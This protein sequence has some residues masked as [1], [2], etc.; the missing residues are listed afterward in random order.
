MTAQEYLAIL[1]EEGEEAAL[2]RI[3]KPQPQVRPV[4][5][6]TPANLD[7]ATPDLSLETAPVREEVDVPMPAEGVNFTDYLVRSGFAPSL[8]PETARRA[9]EID[10]PGIVENVG[11]GLNVGLDGLKIG[12]FGSRALLEDDPVVR[13]EFLTR[14]DEVK[15]KQLMDGYAPPVMDFTEIGNRK[16][17]VED[18]FDWTVG[19]IGTMTPVVGS[20]MAGGFAGGKLGGLAGA[21]GGPKGAA[22]GTLAGSVTGSF[23]VGWGLF[24]GGLYADL[25]EMGASPAVAKKTALGYA[26]APSLF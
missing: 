24:A 9:P 22:I 12:Y 25:I 17:V 23:S 7:I 5:L 13:E 10:D 21:A 26:A 2:Q 19:A 6:S 14:V 15:A 18:A 4:D 20:I 16:G 1:E 11:R 3:D 8:D